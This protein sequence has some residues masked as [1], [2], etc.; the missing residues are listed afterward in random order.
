M[1]YL[2]GRKYHGRVTYVYPT[3]DEIT[4]TVKVRLEFHN[5]GYTLKPGMYVNAVLKSELAKEALLVPDMAVLRSGNANTV[6]VALPAGRF[7]PRKIVLGVRAENDMYQVLSGLKE[8]EKIVISGQF[9]LDSESQ[10]SSALRRLQPIATDG[11]ESL[12]AEQAQASAPE[13]PGHLEYVCPMPEHLSI[14]YEHPGKCPLCGMTMVPIEKSYWDSLDNDGPISY[15]T[16]PMPEHADVKEAK[17]G[18]C[19][20]CG[21]TLIPV[22]E[23]PL[24]AKPSASTFSYYGCPMPEDAD[25]IESKP[26]KCR[27]C[28]MDL[29][30]KSSPS[31]K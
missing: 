29:I 19:P 17:P 26:G 6:F 25:V 18:K 23:K 15:Y 24:P 21:M 9:L 14:T 13:K 12:P 20:K 7:E 30:K 28:G 31:Q 3:V 8:G 2:P 22:R 10:L 16:C 1:S 11:K 27:K 4:R 5:A